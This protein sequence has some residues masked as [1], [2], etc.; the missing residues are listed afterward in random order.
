MHY[1][2]CSDRL[3]QLETGREDYYVSK[4]NILNSF[5][6][7]LFHEEDVHVQLGPEIGK[8][9]LRV[10]AAGLLKKWENDMFVSLV[11]HKMLQDVE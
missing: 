5:G 9:I 10:A 7:W 6:A 8:V 1:A 2:L 11:M 3:S 4:E